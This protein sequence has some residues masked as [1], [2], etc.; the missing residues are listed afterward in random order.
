LFIEAKEG[1]TYVGLCV[2]KIRK[3]HKLNSENQEGK[4]QLRDLTV[5]AKIIF[6]NL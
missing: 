5:D 4:G 1:C 6:K 3:I 2:R